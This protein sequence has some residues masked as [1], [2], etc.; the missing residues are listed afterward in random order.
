MYFVQSSSK[1]IGPIKTDRI[2]IYYDLVALNAKKIVD[3]LIFNF[4]N[5][6]CKIVH[7]IIMSMYSLAFCH[8]LS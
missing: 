6:H 7:N 5:K 1:Q 2:L 4:V 8:F 3:I